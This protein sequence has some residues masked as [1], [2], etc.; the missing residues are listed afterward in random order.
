MTVPRLRDERRDAGAG[1]V[2]SGVRRA[3]VRRQAEDPGAGSPPGPAPRVTTG[4]RAQRG[5]SEDELALARE[6]RISRSA[7]RRFDCDAFARR[8]QVSH[9][10]SPA[11]QRGGTALRSGSGSGGGRF[12]E[13]VQPGCTRATSAGWTTV[14]SSGWTTVVSSTFSRA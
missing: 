10:E 5:D 12:A 3:G 8:R 2:L 7:R 11:A 13:E 14:V 1:R 9:P 6:T 4:R